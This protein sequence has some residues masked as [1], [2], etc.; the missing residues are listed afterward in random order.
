MANFVK[1]H[2]YSFMTQKATNDISILQHL[3]EKCIKIKKYKKLCYRRGA[4]WHHIFSID[5]LIMCE[6]FWKGKIQS[7]YLRA[8]K[9]SSVYFKLNVDSVKKQKSLSC[10]TVVIT[11]CRQEMKI[12]KQNT[13][14]PMT[15][16][17]L[18]VTLFIN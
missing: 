10:W 5:I 17:L 18:V 15:L 14:C 13:A 2:I 12:V 9:L 3:N 11:Q 4:G 6:N 8:L 16:S 7:F 1:L